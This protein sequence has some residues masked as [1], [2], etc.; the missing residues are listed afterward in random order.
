[1][2][3]GREA[4]RAPVVGYGWVRLLPLAG[5]IG[6]VALLHVPEVEPSGWDWLVALASGGLVLAGGRRP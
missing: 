4:L 3:I 1:M 2:R 6:F 5:A